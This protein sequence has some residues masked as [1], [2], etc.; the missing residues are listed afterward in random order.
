MR[1]ECC[2]VL[3]ML[4]CFLLLVA[5][6]LLY[7]HTT[8]HTLKILETFALLAGKRNQKCGERRDKDTKKQKKRKGKEN[9]D[10]FRRTHH[11]SQHHNGMYGTVRYSYDKPDMIRYIPHECDQAII[12]Y[13]IL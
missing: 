5:S 4:C 2:V 7:I 12:L 6:S 13:L 3:F 9:R 1:D 11:N 8:V 10:E